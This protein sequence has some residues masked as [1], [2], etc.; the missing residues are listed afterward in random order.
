MR[1]NEKVKRQQNRSMQPYPIEFRNKIVEAYECENNSIRQIAR[2][3]RVAKSFVQKL[4]KQYKETGDIKPL[5]QGGIPPRKLT[6]EQLVILAE[7][8]NEYNDATLEELCYLLEVKIG[9]KVSRAT[10]GRLTHMLNY[11]FKK[12]S[13]RRRKRK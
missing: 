8:I 11:T 7:I 3:F 13:S 5:R 9:V 10:M 6:N 1:Y 4:L 12:N 2:R